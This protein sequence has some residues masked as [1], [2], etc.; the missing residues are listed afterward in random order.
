MKPLKVL[1]SGN[2]LFS[3]WKFR[4][5]FMLDLVRAGHEVHASA[6]E[7]DDAFETGSLLTEMQAAGVV[8]HALPL[9]RSGLNPVSDLRY[10]FAYLKLC[11]RV[12]PDVV[13]NYTIKPVIWGSLAA[14]LS[15]IGRVY[16][17]ITG[18]GY[19]YTGTAP[20]HRILQTVI[21]ALYRMALPFNRKVVF[22][23]SDDRNLFL[24]RSYVAPSQTALVAGSGIEITEFPFSPL[25]TSRPFRFVCVARMLKDKG[26]L[27]LIEACDLLKAQ[28]LPFEC[29][30]VGGTDANNPA[31]ISE[32]TLL[33][34]QAAGKVRWLGRQSKI[35]EI[36]SEAH[37][38]VLPSYREGTPRS[39]LE[40]LSIGRPVLSTDAPGCRETVN[41]SNGVLVPVQDASALAQA[42]KTFMEFSQEQLEHMGTASRAMAEKTFDVAKV[43]GDL[44]ELMNLKRT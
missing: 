17:M 42:M 36:L 13:F 35:A 12:K 29:L 33:A 9:S 21:G 20:K 43:N 24:K 16:S 40:A 32:E 41:S 37:V 4:R 38:F 2:T 6:G 11:K 1:V 44:F 18:L 10:F 7:K 27:E 23:N 25:P 5:S 8:F 19:A 15:N 39:T 26:I 28:G 14:A 30:L 3:L 31:S 34:A 22:Q